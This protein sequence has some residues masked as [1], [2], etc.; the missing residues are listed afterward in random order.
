MGREYIST[1]HFL[2]YDVWTAEHTAVEQA[3][4]FSS[5]YFKWP[6]VL[7]CTLLTQEAS[8]KYRFSGVSLFLKMVLYLQEIQF[9][10]L[11][12]LK[13]AWIPFLCE[14]AELG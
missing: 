1:P 9:S 8:V 6:A 7:S 11:L 12:Q 14:P 5:V 13:M 3:K 10:V 2:L 4:F